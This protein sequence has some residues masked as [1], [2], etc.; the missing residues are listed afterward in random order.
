MESPT[1]VTMRGS[2][3]SSR[4]GS[5]PS[6]SLLGGTRLRP[7]TRELAKSGGP[8][9]V[10]KPMF[11][12]AERF[13]NELKKLVYPSGYMRKTVVGEKGEASVAD[14]TRM[15]E[16][17]YLAGELSEEEASLMMRA[18]DDAES[19]SNVSFVEVFS[20]TIPPSVRSLQ[21]SAESSQAMLLQSLEKEGASAQAEQYQKH[22]AE[23][24]AKYQEALA[25]QMSL[26]KD[27]FVQVPIGVKSFEA[28][29]PVPAEVAQREKKQNEL[30][31]QRQK[32]RI[33]TAVPLVGKISQ[34]VTTNSESGPEVLVSAAESS[35]Q[36][37]S[38]SLLSGSQTTT[39]SF[40][41]PEPPTPKNVEVALKAQLKS[42]LGVTPEESKPKGLERP[43]Q[44]V[45]VNV[46]RGGGED[47]ILLFVFNTQ[48]MIHTWK[49]AN[50]EALENN[51]GAAATVIKAPLDF[52]YDELESILHKASASGDDNE[53]T[54]SE[55]NPNKQI[56]K[57]KFFHEFNK[58]W[59]D[60]NN[61][62][63]WRD[64]FNIAK[65]QRRKLFLSASLLYKE[66]DG[67]DEEMDEILEREEAER[68]AKERKAKSRVKAN[69]NAKAEGDEKKHILV[70]FPVVPQTFPNVLLERE[71]K[72]EEYYKKKRKEWE[73]A[74]A[75]VK[76]KAA[77]GGSSTLSGSL[78]MSTLERGSGALLSNTGLVDEYVG[79]IGNGGGSKSCL[80]NTV[81]GARVGAL[82]V[83]DVR[84]LGR[85]RSKKEIV[86]ILQKSLKQS[87]KKKKSTY[88]TM[89]GRTNY[90]F[91]NSLTKYHHDELFGDDE[92]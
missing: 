37:L 52:S 57:V 69:A 80:L 89:A 45:V 81:M 12:G 43:A 35:A 59:L 54:Q 30:Q 21:A 64:A 75:R 9:F 83:K 71:A 53:G 51:A 38:M 82:R 92:D 66:D 14:S 17:L 86:N 3:P 73:E 11:P 55:L 88:V 6:S 40:A 90:A 36:S 87:T 23:M 56:M 63:D 13:E 67:G 47:V 77:G 29:I 22:I 85:E 18:E 8:T 15:L 76:R 34:S 39:P 50:I 78:S 70:D 28:E 65:L 79:R 42:D 61:E 84:E 24:M 7:V 44:S 4:P 1:K 41:P 49:G 62:I 32:Q 91:G 10:H 25:Q 31:R 33:V 72:A 48:Q 46:A 74:S 27:D 5:R 2:T 26:G 19:A 16:D 20:G 68:E 60:L 58:D